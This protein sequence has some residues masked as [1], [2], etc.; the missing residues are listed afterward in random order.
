M[1]NNEEIIKQYLDFRRDTE[2]RR[3]EKTLRTENFILETF[4]KYLKNKKFKTAT[5]K[6]IIDYLK[7]YSEKTRDDRIVKLKKFYRWL[8][9]VEKGE[10]LPDCVR[11]IKRSV[12]SPIHYY[13]ETEYRKRV[14]LEEEFQRLIDNS[15]TIMQ[16]AIIETLYHFGI[17]AS[18]LLSM[19]A[20][21]VEHKKGITK[22]TVEDSK[23]ETR[24]VIYLGKP[25]Y[26]MK[27]FKEYQHFKGQPDKPLWTSF[28]KNKYNRYSY[29]ALEKIILSI[30][31]KAGIKRK[32]SPHD[33]RHTAITNARKNG[34]KDTHIQTNFGL[35]KTSVM[36]GV[37]DHNKTKDYEEE[38]RKRINEIP[39]DEN[40]LKKQKERLEQK[41]E[42]EIQK[43]KKKNAEM[44]NLIKKFQEEK[45]KEQEELSK[46]IQ[47][48]IIEDLTG[49]TS[50]KLYE[51]H[52]KEIME[53]MTGETAKK[54]EE[55]I[56]KEIME[57]I[58]GETAKK[59]EE[60]I[61]KEIMEEITGEGTKKS[62]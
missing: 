30:S 33:F 62:D 31:K 41:H 43:L 23:T 42:K 57:E 21:G 49:E 16:K 14:I 15:K 55:Q 35:S 59:L 58:T 6:D 27:W 8:Y 24:D 38:L 25:E 12:G 28:I 5:E 52:M 39:T 19:N 56:K 40:L 50:K 10:R 2:N 26:L 20:T 37:Y 54:L 22:I 48:E 53:E 45:Q 44:H 47:Q 36:M 32:I 11:R 60:Q 13:K 4:S 51:E 17:R 3:N 46:K 7:N 61:K 1:T 29:S 9:D 18:E 34:E